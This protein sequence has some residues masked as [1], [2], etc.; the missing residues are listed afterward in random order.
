MPVEN[1]SRERGLIGVIAPVFAIMGLKLVVRPTGL[2]PVATGL[3]GRIAF[4][5]LSMRNT[6]TTAR[7]TMRATIGQRNAITFPALAGLGVVAA[8]PVMA[9][10]TTVALAP[11]M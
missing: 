1:T 5:V 6:A 4:T 7:A 2:E 3:E 9:S 8:M 10:R 11:R